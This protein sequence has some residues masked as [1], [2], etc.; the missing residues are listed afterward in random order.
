MKLRLLLFVLAALF[1]VGLFAQ[2]PGLVMDGGDDFVGNY[3]DILDMGLSD[4]SFQIWFNTTDATGGLLGKTAYSGL[5]GRWG[6][7]FSEGSPNTLRVLIQGASTIVQL[8]ALPQQPGS[9]KWND[10]LWHNATV[11]ADRDGLLSLYMDGV[12]N[13]TISMTSL[14][15]NNINSSGYFFLGA[16]G[17]AAGTS[18]QAN[19]FLNGGIDEARVW[20]KVLSPAEIAANW[21]VEIT[22]PQNNLV[23]YWQMNEDT[24]TIIQDISGNDY[25]GTLY[26]GVTWGSGPVT[27]PVEL[28]TFTATLTSQYFVEI[29]WVTESETSTMGFVIF[30]SEDN[31]LAHAYQVSPLINATNTT[32][33]VT[34]SYT[35]TEVSPG[36]WY[37]WLQNINLDGSS[38]FHGPVL[39]NVYI[40]PDIDAPEIPIVTSISNVFPN[41]FNPSTSI[42]YSLKESVPVSFKI[43]NTRGQLVQTF[44]FTNR[45]AGHHDLIWDASGLPSGVYLIRMQAGDT[46]SNSKAV[47]SK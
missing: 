38:Q 44:S 17:N 40:N 27:L 31:N 11:T 36:T 34:Y 32:T 25:D 15:R 10:G 41:P 28:S 21:N 42:N 2:T 7:F 13:N 16:Y 37:Y 45:N 26:G 30:R 22:A 6:I 14:E 12:L 33:Q 8:D 47:L 9:V 5:T 1:T 29:H 46:I 24:G 3:G 23:G 19:F 43:Y 35:D 20:N 4:W 39:A 18:P